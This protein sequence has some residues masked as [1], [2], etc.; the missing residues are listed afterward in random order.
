MVKPEFDCMGE[1]IDYLEVKVTYV[2][3]TV[4]GSKV[5]LLDTLSRKEFDELKRC[6]NRYPS[7]S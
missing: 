5:E 2:K 1:R 7:T 3:D 6:V 4:N